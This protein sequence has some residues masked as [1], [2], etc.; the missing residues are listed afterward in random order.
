[1]A[2]FAKRRTCIKIGEI[3]RPIVQVGLRCTLGRQERFALCPS[4]PSDSKAKIRATSLRRKQECPAK[5]VDRL[6][7]GLVVD[8]CKEKRVAKVD[9]VQAEVYSVDAS[10]SKRVIVLTTPCRTSNSCAQ[11]MQQ[12]EKSRQGTHKRKERYTTASG[13]FHQAYENISHA[14]GQQGSLVEGRLSNSRGGQ[15]AAARREEAFAVVR[16]PDL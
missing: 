6:M 16:Q 15:P 9:I 14:S 2:L 3:D 10:N 11:Q 7:T 12:W 8:Q 13:Y 4:I 1:V 5:L